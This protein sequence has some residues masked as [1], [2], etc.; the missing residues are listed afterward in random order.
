MPVALPNLLL[1]YKQS[2]S[3]L[4]NRCQ[5]VVHTL[6]CSVRSMHA[7]VDSSVE[8][9]V[10]PPATIP[11]AV[12]MAAVVAAAVFVS[13]AV[14]GVGRRAAACHVVRCSAACRLAVVLAVASMAAVSEVKV[15]NCAAVAGHRSL[16]HI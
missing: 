4:L 9:D 3:N 2:H 15:S 10:F 12:M 6:K 7:A 14:T 13:T 8:V 16:Q 5:C 1:S 11:A